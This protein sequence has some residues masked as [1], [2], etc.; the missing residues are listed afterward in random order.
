MKRIDPPRMRPGGLGMSRMMESAVMLLPQPLSP[1]MA[2]D[3]PSMRSKVTPST[4]FTT[5]ADVKKCVRRPFT[6]R[7]A[8]K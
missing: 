2:S 3:S 7:R 8:V 6:S 5:P 1:T 4:A